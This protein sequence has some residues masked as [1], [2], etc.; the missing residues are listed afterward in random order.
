[1]KTLGVYLDFSLSFNDHY[2]HIQNRASSMLGFIMRNCNNFDNPLALKS[3]Y[4]AF[5]SSILDYNSIIWSPYTSGQIHSLEVIQNR[6]LRLISIKC[7]I[8]R[9]PHT[10]YE[11]LLLYLNIDTLQIRRVKH[12]ICFLY[13]LLN[14]YIYCPDLLSNFFFIV[15][16]HTTNQT[17]TYYVPFQRTV[18]SKNAPIIRFMQHVNTFNIDVFICNSV[19]SFKFYL[20]NLVI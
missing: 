20:N 12:D 2:I 13:K 11:L 18:H 16:D 6:F 19:S 1:V 7:N 8:Q 15:P 10:S 17:D 5:A 3:L 14:G 4:C 9:L